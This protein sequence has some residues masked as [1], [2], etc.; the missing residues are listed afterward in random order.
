MLFSCTLVAALMT[1]FVVQT[2]PQQNSA[3]F[4]ITI[5]DCSQYIPIAVYQMMEQYNP[6]SSS[7]LMIP[8]QYLQNCLNSTAYNKYIGP[9]DLD[10]KRWNGCESIIKS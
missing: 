8:T 3:F 9:Y 2:T 1:Q 4:G 5:F 6:D 7:N 10:T